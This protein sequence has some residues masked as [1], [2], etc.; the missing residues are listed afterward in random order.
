MLLLTA[1]VV[2]EQAHRGEL[3]R[4]VEGE[5]GTEGR[6]AG[7]CEE[8]GWLSERVGRGEGRMGRSVGGDS[9]Q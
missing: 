6:T 8:L 9:W 2:V 5:M 4:I 3:G 1:V 7:H